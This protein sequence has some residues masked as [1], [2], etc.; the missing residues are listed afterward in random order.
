MTIPVTWASNS[1]PWN[2]AL[3]CFPASKRENLH[4]CV[5]K[6]PSWVPSLPCVFS[7]R[8]TWNLLPPGRWQSWLWGSK[9]TRWVMCVWKRINILPLESQS[10]WI[11]NAIK[12]SG[13]VMSF[14]SWVCERKW[15]VSRKRALRF[16]IMCKMIRTM[17]L[18]PLF[19]ELCNRSAHMLHSLSEIPWNTV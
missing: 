4:N 3:L 13:C 2:Y 12:G 16:F 8:E 19:A 5:I 6:K 17:I 11:L 10:D 9:G 18:L 14:R 7:A 1:W 15:P